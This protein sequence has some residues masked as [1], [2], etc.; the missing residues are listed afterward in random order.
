MHR[1]GPSY[2]RV[3]LGPESFLDLKN[4]KWDRED[5]NSETDG[6]LRLGQ[7][8]TLGQARKFSFIKEHAL[9]WAIMNLLDVVHLPLRQSPPLPTLF[10][11]P[12]DWQSQNPLLSGFGLTLTNWRRGQEIP[13][14]RRKAAREFFSPVFH[15]PRGCGLAMLLC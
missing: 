1:Q 6:L 9:I 8:S 14:W 15:L 13:V 3:Q 2:R 10:C 11:A 7:G 12:T 5:Y 4:R